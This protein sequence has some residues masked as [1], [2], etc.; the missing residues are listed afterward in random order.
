MTGSFTPASV[1]EPSSL[2]GL[3]GSG[4]FGLMGFV[5]RKRK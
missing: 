5:W 1:P 4:L 3:L 2:V